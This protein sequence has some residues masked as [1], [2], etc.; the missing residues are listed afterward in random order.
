LNS[1]NTSTQILFLLIVVLTLTLLQGCSSQ[2][3]LTAWEGHLIDD[4]ITS[5]GQPDSIN[6]LGDNYASYT[7]KMNQANCEK[8]FTA[9]DQ[10][11]TGYSSS[12]CEN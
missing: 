1:R 7:W 11:I 9:S 3:S 5:W 4:L 12:G 6:Q 2:S 10:I 8:T